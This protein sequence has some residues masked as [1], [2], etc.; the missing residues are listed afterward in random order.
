MDLDT[1]LQAIANHLGAEVVSLRERDLTPELL[2]TIPANTAR[3]YHCL[4]VGCRFARA[5]RLGRS[6]E[7]RPHR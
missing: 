3:M 6:A 2:Q 1:I 4:P 5:G 7:P